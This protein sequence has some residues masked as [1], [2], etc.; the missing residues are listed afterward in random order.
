M[1]ELNKKIMDSWFEIR[2]NLENPL[3]LQDFF[4]LS[5][6]ETSEAIEKLHNAVENGIFE[7]KKNTLTE[8]FYIIDS[9][10]YST[11]A[12]PKLKEA[13]TNIKCLTYVII[14]QRLIVKK[15]VK[16]KDREETIHGDE[17]KK[18]TFNEIGEIV[19]SVQSLVLE[20]PEIKKDKRIH[21]IIT[22]VS[23][24]NSE[25][26]SMNKVLSHVPEEKKQGV[27]TN[28]SKSLN[29]I[30][31]K[32]LSNYK[33]VI[34]DLEKK[35]PRQQHLFNLYDLSIVAD[36]LK[37][38]AEITD[39]I[40]TTFLFAEEERFKILDILAT[41]QKFKKEIMQLMENEEKHYYNAAFSE[42]G[43]RKIKR[44]FCLE[45]IKIL[46]MPNQV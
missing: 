3:K 44:E 46:E 7:Y 41:L 39:R 10:N 15:L 31:S 4:A 24:F 23:K 38:Q 14:I 42:S 16:I 45:I 30:F 2:S 27:K 28:Y 40:K 5:I 8:V 33:E 12:L 17:E 22:Q 37:K 29:E 9:L 11:A 36:G 18:Y 6:E 32:L 43:K 1:A 26:E 25:V 20:N 13:V 35:V 34:R 19:K 21:N